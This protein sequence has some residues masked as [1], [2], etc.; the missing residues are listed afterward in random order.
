MSEPPKIIFLDIDG[1][2]NTFTDETPRSRY[3]L[4]PRCVENLNKI[5]R[6]TQAKIV[7]S[8]TWR[9]LFKTPKDLEKVL[10]ESGFEGEIFDFTDS[11]PNYYSVRGNEIKKWLEDHEELLGVPYYDFSSYIILDDDSDM[12][13][14]QKDNFIHVNNLIGINITVIKQ[15]LRKLL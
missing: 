12:L 9:F 5:I 8:S 3:P 4:L 10:K 15:S 2:L 7:V 1:V 14:E 11:L 6:E 13:L